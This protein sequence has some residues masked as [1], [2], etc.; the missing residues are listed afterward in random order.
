[1]EVMSTTTSA[2]IWNNILQSEQDH[3]SP[4]TAR[5]ILKLD[6]DKSDHARMESLSTKAQQGKLTSKERADLE[7][8]VRISDLL[9]ILQSKA[10]TALRQVAHE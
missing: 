2:V 4:E 5:Y 9:A 7:E 8:Y 1:M 3:L 6:F 10:R